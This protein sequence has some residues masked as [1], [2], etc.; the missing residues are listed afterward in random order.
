[1][2]KTKIGVS[3]AIASAAVYLLVLFGGYTAALLL[4]GYIFLCEQSK[5]LKV[6]VLTAVAVALAY[7]VGNTLL[8]LP[9]NLVAILDNFLSLFKIYVSMNDIYN[10]FNL[11]TNIWSLIKT[12][13]LVLLSVFAFIG[14]PVQLGFIKKIVAE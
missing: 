8:N 12:V 4:L 2:E 11:L 1:M 9:T 5:D 3:V 14:K 13:A 7:S 6:S 10:F